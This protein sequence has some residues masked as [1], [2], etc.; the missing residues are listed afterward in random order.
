MLVDEIY[1][2]LKEA[3]KDVDVSE[4]MSFIREE[5]V[6]R[7]ARFYPIWQIDSIGANSNQFMSHEQAIKLSFEGF[8][9]E[10]VMS[11]NSIGCGVHFS[12]YTVSW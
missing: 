9:V 12:G 8:T 11:P 4:P 1:A 7:T 2:E 10:K 3:V 5:I 6:N